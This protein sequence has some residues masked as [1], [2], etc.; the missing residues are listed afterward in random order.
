M[1]GYLPKDSIENE[2]EDLL[3]LK[4]SFD[5]FSE[6]TKELKSSYLK[7]ED[8][9][10][11]LERELIDKVNELKTKSHY[12]KE[13]LRQISQGII[14][15]D[16]DGTIH[17]FNDSAGTFFNKDRKEIINQNFWD[18]FSDN[19][20]GFSMKSAL[21]HQN[22]PGSAIIKDH[23][24]NTYEITPTYLPFENSLQSS[25]QLF[26]L[27]RNI[28][29]YQN[30]KVLAERNN[31]LSELGGMAAKLAHEIRNPLGGIKGFAE[32]LLRDLE[33]N[34]K[35][36]Q[37]ARHISDGADHLDKLVSS[38]LIYSKPLDLDLVEV[39]LCKE[40]QDFQDWIQRDT[41]FEKCQLRLHLSAKPQLA[42]VDK[43]QLRSCLFNLVRNAWQSMDSKGK[44]DIYLNRDRSY[45]VIRIIDYGKGIPKE[46]QEKIFSPFFTTKH[47]GYGVGLSEV[48]KILQAHQGQIAL[49]SS[50]NKGSIFCITLPAYI[51][52]GKDEENFNR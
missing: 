46:L 33:G 32:L 21:K 28:T 47:S 2:N 48:H 8:K 26:I 9:Y 44:I 38:V 3:M 49:E 18:Y 4:R 12:L 5:I 40:L 42:L 13:V 41:F 15:I 45:I 50:S 7:L 22:A 30:L 52:R 20:L 11:D 27:I 35:L 1:S 19:D 23:N 34:E 16:P 17:L 14:M 39:D 6:K 43:F 24:H 25:F 37:M 10:T 31:R 29:D 51:K 36:V